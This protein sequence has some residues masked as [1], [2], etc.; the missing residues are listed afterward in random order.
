LEWL[1]DSALHRGQS[2]ALGRCDLGDL[3]HVRLFSRVL[4]EYGS[5]G[6]TNRESSD[7]RG[8]AVSRTV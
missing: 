6:R 2:D 3:F 4:R 5:P 8:S 1:A 7:G